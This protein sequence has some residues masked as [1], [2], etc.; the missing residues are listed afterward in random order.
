MP[1]PA[2]FLDRDGTLIEERHYLSDPSQV[3]LFPGA[4]EALRQLAR[5]GYALV[6]VTNQSGI[7]RG[8][9]TEDQLRDVHRHLAETL[10]AAGIRIDGIFHC[11]HAPAEACDCRKPS[12]GLVHRA[13][14]DLDLDPARSFVI[15]D[16]P[17]D[18]ALGVRV[19]A[20]PILVL[21]GYGETSMR[22][23]A[24]AA[25][26]AHIAQDLAAAARHVLSFGNPSIDRAVS[27][28]ESPTPE[29]AR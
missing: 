20:R 27:G 24:V 13:C 16:K 28:S 11:P 12:P 10:A 8:L 23:P 17:A 19:G 26:S 9:F 14:A 6:I 7:G 21:T 1:K 25:S 5:A 15:G 3:A 29:S 2:I 18:V 4:V 22:D